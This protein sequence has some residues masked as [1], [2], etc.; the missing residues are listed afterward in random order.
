MDPAHLQALRAIHTDAHDFYRAQLTGEASDGRALAFLRE[1]GVTDPHL[2]DATGLGY[3]PASWTALTDHLRARGYTDPQLLDSGLAMTTRRGTL[4]DRFRDRVMFPVH[5]HR[6]TAAAPGGAGSI[7]GFLGR[8]LD[9]AAGTDSGPP[10]YLNSPETP[11]YRKGELLYGLADPPALDRLT[12]HRVVPVVV[13]GPLDRLSVLAA[14]EHYLPVA[15]CGTALTAAQVQALDDIVHLAGREVVT[16]FDSDRAGSDSALRAY[17]VLRAAGA[18]PTVP[19][20]HPATT[21]PRTRARWAGCARRC[22]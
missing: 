10:K 6:D 22:D 18:W 1:R 12:R 15:P 13:E 4:V 20:C 19:R 9:P 5:D 14:G 17:P 21:P 2:I 3:A 8:S 16:A 7:V 11:L